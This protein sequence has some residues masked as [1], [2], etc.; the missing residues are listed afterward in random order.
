[1]FKRVLLNIHHPLDLNV[2]RFEVLITYGPGIVAAVGP[3]L[4]EPLFVFAK[5]NVGV[6]QRPATESA[7]NQRAR[8]LERPDVEHAVASRTRIPKVFT[9]LVG[10]ARERV[11]R[12]CLAAL[13]QA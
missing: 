3:I 1:M 10:G 12:I 7:G 6:D 8:S 2:M 4:L 9:Q 11:W 5:V 13:Q